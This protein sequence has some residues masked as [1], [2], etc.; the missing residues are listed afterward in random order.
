MLGVAA[1]WDFAFNFYNL[2]VLPTVLGLGEDAGVHILHRWLEEGPGSVA[3]VVHSTGEAVLMCT[4]TN[5]LGFSGMITSFHP[6]LRSMGWLAVVGIGSTLI[7]SLV[8]LPALLQVV[9]DYRARR[10]AS[11]SR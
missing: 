7:A 2:V 10:P 9:D 5:M 1:H 8:S 4:A 11:A 3:R 6:G